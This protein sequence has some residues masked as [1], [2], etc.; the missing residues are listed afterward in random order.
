MVDAWLKILREREVSEAVQTH[1]ISL[2]DEPK[3]QPDPLIPYEDADQIDSRPSILVEDATVHDSRPPILAEDDRL[4]FLLQTIHSQAPMTVAD[5]NIA[6]NDGIRANV[7][8]EPLHEGTAR[9]RNKELADVCQFN[10]YLA[11]WYV[12]HVARG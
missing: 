11:Q 8:H 9:T 6:R 10:L 2:A 1:P 4:Q 5:V 3:N 7:Q 12:S